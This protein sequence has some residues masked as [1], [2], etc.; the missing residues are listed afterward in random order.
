[1]QFSDPVLPSLAGRVRSALCLAVSLASLCSF[2]AP[3]PAPAP[4]VDAGVEAG[5]VYREHTVL[6]GKE[7]RVTDPD[8]RWATAD[9][10][11]P[12]PVLTL[13]GVRLEHAIGAELIL[14]YWHGH[15]GTR[16]KVVRIN[17]RRWMP[18][19]PV[20][21]G[22]RGLDPLNVSAQ[23]NMRLPVPLGDLVEGDNTLQ[24]S[25][26]G[27]PHGWGQWGWFA[28]QLR[29]R[30]DP[31]AVAPLAMA[32]ETSADAEG[33]LLENPTFSLK[34]E[35]PEEV[36]EVRYVARHLG[37]DVDGDG[38]LEA[39]H[40]MLRK[41]GFEGHVGT[42]TQPP[43]AVTWDTS[44]VPD[45]RAGAIAVQ[46]LVLDRAGIWRASP[47]V[48]GLSLPRKEH[49]VRLYRPVQQIAPFTVRNNG[50]K[51]AVVFLPMNTDLSH[52]VE[53][54]VYLRTF[55]G[56]NHELG[57]TPMRFNAS[58]WLEVVRGA[59]NYF[60]SGLFEIDP[61]WLLEGD[62]MIAFHSTSTHH[63]PEILWPGPL[64]L[65]RYD[66]ATPVKVAASSA[67]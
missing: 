1:M 39:F 48:E 9:R 5:A 44:W 26:G 28:A 7:W 47:V 56:K 58:P 43:F 18:V 57:Y 16:D 15:P 31:A 42:A 4:S 23:L 3:L 19:E 40:G 67:H 66:T 6:I 24:G 22:L 63:G 36:V 37:V 62:N 29:V 51:S 45:Q 64:V 61:K 41:E 34:V 20:F 65:V 33:N 8:V 11:L 49:S 25:C 30:L 50:V 21:E 27:N 55:N 60:H 35:R 12:N 2:A 46:A 53:A 54:R 13:P 59:N 17:R 10:Y 32:V 14:D 38:R 52:A